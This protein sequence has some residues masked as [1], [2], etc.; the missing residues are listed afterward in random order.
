[1]TI[2]EFNQ[3]NQS[4]KAE[5][6][7]NSRLLAERVENDSLFRLYY[8]KGI[9]VEVWLN[10]AHKQVYGMKPFLNTKSLAC[11]LDEVSIS[12]I[13]DLFKAL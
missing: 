13:T 3:L 12:E 5:L 2:F 9:Y 7:L 10:P 1:M 8:S 4:E 6:V 11:Y